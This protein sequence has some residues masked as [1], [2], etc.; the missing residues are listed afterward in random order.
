MALIGVSALISGH[1]WLLKVDTAAVTAIEV[2][3]GRVYSASGLSGVVKA[4]TPLWEDATKEKVIFDLFVSIGSYRKARSQRAVRFESTLQVRKA[5][6]AWIR[7]LKSRSVSLLYYFVAV[8]RIN[9]HFS[10]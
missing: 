3:W 2:A 8:K 5:R 10:R 4:W 9:Q 7:C 1:P 6:W